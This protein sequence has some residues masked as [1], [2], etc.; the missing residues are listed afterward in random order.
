[1]KKTRFLV[2]A[3]AVAVMLMGAGYAWWTETVVI[4]TEVSTGE[5]NVAIDSATASADRDVLVGDP[6]I[7][8]DAFGQDQVK[9]KFDKMYPGAKG[10]AVIKIKNTGTVQVKVD[11]PIVAFGDEDAGRWNGIFDFDD[12]V[13]TPSINGVDGTPITLTRQTDFFG[14]TIAFTFNENNPILI[15][16]GQSATFSLNVKMLESVT[17]EENLGDIWFTFTPSFKQYNA[18]N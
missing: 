17:G 6:V 11:S 8:V 15:D 4:H 7:G 16:P 13:F 14:N 3:L 12:V 1:M 2:L 10:N 9:L 5:L 18:P